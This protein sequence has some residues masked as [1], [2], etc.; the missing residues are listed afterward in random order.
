MRRAALLAS[1]FIAGSLAAETVA[2]RCETQTLPYT[3]G[4][5]IRR[6]VSCSENATDDTLWHLDRLDSFDG[7]LDG[8]FERARST[9]L[10]YVFDTGVDKTHDEFADGNL[11]GGIDAT[12]LEGEKNDC[13]DESLNPCLGFPQFALAKSHGTGVASLI[14]GRRV[15]VAPGT[16]IVSIHTTSLR[17]TTWLRAL[18]ETIKH[19][20]LPTTPQVRTAIINMSSQPA[21]AV[22][23]GGVD[24]AN[25][26]KF[27]AKI[28][29]MVGGV[30]RDGHPDSNG[31]RFLFVVAGGN[32]ADPATAGGNRGQCGPNN[33]VALFPATLG[34]SIAGLITV[35]GATRENTFW[36]G[37]CRSDAI[38]L[39]GPAEEVL[40][41]I[42]TAPNDYRLTADSGTSWSTPVVAGVAALLLTREPDLSPAELEA[43]LEATPSAISNPPPGA[44]GGR[45]VTTPPRVIPARR[46]GAR[47]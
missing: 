35:G 41:A 28:R 42:N 24:Y 38:E 32:S 2:T 12:L 39:L 5:Q 7:H 1:L 47:H 31:K 34:P 46:R 44:A 45:M 25:Q 13:G 16:S 18:D 17:Y 9:A 3:T 4:V 10:V 37:S 11:I 29:D 43:R 40:P 6:I 23:P 15:G 30:D 8:R 27:E 19:A 36:S 20:W 21:F 26:Q 14:G 22:G 33:E